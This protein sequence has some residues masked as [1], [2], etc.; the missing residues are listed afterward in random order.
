MEAGITWWPQYFLAA[1][2]TW[3]PLSPFRYASINRRDCVA[4]LNWL[5]FQISLW[6]ISAVL[7][8]TTACLSTER[9]RDIWSHSFPVRPHLKGAEAGDRYVSHIPSTAQ[10]NWAHSGI[11]EGTGHNVPSHAC[12][13]QELTW[14]SRNQADWKA[15]NDSSMLFLFFFFFFFFGG[16]S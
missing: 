14:C 5:N 4:K 7:R 15:W 16:A 12:C 1:H 3:Q 2:A 8:L 13:C 9:H 11:L 6:S 10:W